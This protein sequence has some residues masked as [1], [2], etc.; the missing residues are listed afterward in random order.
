MGTTGDGSGRTLVPAP[1]DIARNAFGGITAAMF[2]AVFD[3]SPAGLAVLVGPDLIVDHANAACRAL[4]RADVDPVGQPF[5]DVWPTG[6]PAVLPALRN[7]LATGAGLCVDDYAVPA[8]GGVRRFCVQVRR[9]PWRRGL[10]VLVAVWETSEAWAARRAA[11]EA[12]AAA[13]TRAGELDATVDAIADGLVIYGR[14]GEIL[15]MNRA[16]MRQLG[17]DAGEA[18][19]SFAERFAALRVYAPD[20][21]LM[22]L[23]DTPVVRALQGE[24]VRSL[25]ARVEYQGR[26]LWVLASSAPVRGAD[27]SI[28]GAVLTFSDETALHAMEQARD[29][30][31]RMI[32]HDLRTP[33]NAIYN[34]A[35][36]LRRYPNDAARVEARAAAVLK[37]CERMSAMIQDLVEATLLEDGQLQISPEPV[38]LAAAVPELLER[39]HGAIDVDRVRLV[40]H[41]D[42][43][44]ALADP[45]RLERIVV[46]LLTNA[47]KYSP[48]QGEVVL[49]LAP[50][51][52]G[53]AIVVTDRGVGIAPED[54]P[55]V[56][57][58]FFRAR[59]AR[60]PEGLGLGLYITRHLVQAHGGR[61][62]V[63]SRLGQGST[64]RVVLPS[65][66]GNGVAALH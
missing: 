8:A 6:D 39:F 21:R 15:R 13:L 46:N 11:E 34:Q 53:V 52:E 64:F 50:A 23:E 12:A 62:E 26:S 27:G 31:V 14:D 60:Q 30:L 17:Y 58:R 16:A 7:V 20:G 57:D 54:V 43:P 51:P 65:A 56:F 48:P 2:E 41:P 28:A 24:T 4:T 18:S 3:A 22:R 29:D 63:S 37:S 25:H 66:D 38:D 55:H 47:L 45:Q 33:L 32:S 36:L 42:L 35:H 5:E 19:P 61:I 10:A 40:V 1:G 59:G 44:R 49:E 9:I